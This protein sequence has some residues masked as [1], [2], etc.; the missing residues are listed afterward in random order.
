M[1]ILRQPSPT[2]RIHEKIGLGRCPRF[3]FCLEGT[4][5]VLEQSRR[6]RAGC[7]H[8][9]GNLLL[10]FRR[11]LQ[12]QSAKITADQEVAAERDHRNKEQG[13]PALRF[14][15]SENGRAA[16]LG[17]GILDLL[18]RFRLCS[19]TKEKKHALAPCSVL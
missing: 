14:H 12:G 19:Y 5:P 2:G 1:A 18:D 11:A 6:L 9:R 16:A 8:L 15:G 10:Q 4:V 7:H 3:R 13:E 17:A